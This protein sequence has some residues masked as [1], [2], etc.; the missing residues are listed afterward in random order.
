MEEEEEENHRVDE[1]RVVDGN[2]AL[3]AH[4]YGDVVVERLRELLLHGLHVLLVQV[5]TDQ[6]DAAV[7]IVSD[8]A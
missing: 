8:A 7:D 4:A 5:G 6:A 3:G 1:I 2:D